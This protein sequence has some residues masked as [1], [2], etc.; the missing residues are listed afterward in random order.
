MLLDSSSMILLLYIVKKIKT[1]VRNACYHIHIHLIPARGSASPVLFLTPSLP[2]TVIF[3]VVGVDLPI[4]VSLT[5][6][7][8]VIEA[9]SDIE[10]EILVMF[11][12]FDKFITV[13]LPTCAYIV[14]PTVPLSCSAGIEILRGDIITKIV[15]TI[16]FILIL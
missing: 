12:L 2:S 15:N 13:G 11:V 1:E 10:G 7:A 4:R 5:S 16:M 14:C 3:E 8:D 6:G 9:F